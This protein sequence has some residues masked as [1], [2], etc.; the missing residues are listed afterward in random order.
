LKKKKNHWGTRP[1]WRRPWFRLLIVSKYSYSF[2]F[3]AFISS[4]FCFY[5][6]ILMVG[7]CVIKVDVHMNYWWCKFNNQPQSICVGSF[8]AIIQ[9]WNGHDCKEP[10]CSSLFRHKVNCMFCFLPCAFSLG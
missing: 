9:W 8:F 4:A 6:C 10:W 3:F 5:K 1:F 2:C 7:F